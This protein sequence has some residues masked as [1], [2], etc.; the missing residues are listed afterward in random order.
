MQTNNK[1]FTQAIQRTQQEIQKELHELQTERV[2][3]EDKKHEIL[4]LEKDIATL[5]ERAKVDAIKKQADQKEIMILEMKIRKN[6]DRIRAL[7]S[8]M[9]QAQHEATVSIK[10]AGI[11]NI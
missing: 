7:N 8:E 3:L 11:K 2:S 6:E 10:H 5:Q 1:D 4:T 9:T